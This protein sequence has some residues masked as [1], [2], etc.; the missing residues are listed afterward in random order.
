M[1]I[2]IDVRMWSESGIGRYIRN[3]VANLILIDSK[4]QFVL[5]GLSKDRAEVESIIVHSTAR[6]VT[7]DF[8]WY[9]LAEQ[10]Y[11]PSLLNREKLDLVHFP[12]FNV[13]LGYFGRYVVTIHDLTHFSFRMLRSTQLS[14]ILYQVKQIGHWVAFCSAVYRSERIIVVSKYVRDEICRRF[15]TDQQRVIVTYESGDALSAIGG[16]DVEIEIPGDYFFYV[17]NAHP[18]KNLELL[19]ESF[20]IFH[21]SNPL[22]YLVL[23]GRRNFF[24]QQVESFAHA[25]SLD[26]HVKFVGEV[27]DV[28]LKNLYSRATAFVFPSLSEGFGLPLLEAMYQNCPVISSSATCL[29]E[30]AGD[31]AVYF[32]PFSEVALV[33]VMQRVASE[34]ALRTQLIKEG[35]SQVKKFSWKKMAE[36]TLKIYQ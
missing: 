2:G 13:P 19:L 35:Q 23:A 15:S 20:A 25:N 32:D 30:I 10:L 11:F 22:F 6:F 26:N 14:P 24:W 12:H 17:G 16:N 8:R 4:D 28:Q 9:T 7:A 27:S 18:H 3:L 5:F 33:D 21:K 34:S 36:E 29:P 1:R 31:A